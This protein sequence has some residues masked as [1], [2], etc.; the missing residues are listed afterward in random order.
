MLRAGPAH[1][2]YFFGSVE[3]W[4]AGKKV[5]GPVS[6]Y[7]PDLHETKAV[8]HALMAATLLTG[9]PVAPERHEAALRLRDQGAQAL[10]A[11]ESGADH[12]KLEQRTRLT[13]LLRL[14]LEFVD[15]ELKA[16]ADTARQVFAA[17]VRPIVKEVMVDA[18]RVAIGNLNA[19]VTTFQKQ[20]GPAAWKQLVVVAAVGHQSR[21]KEAGVRSKAGKA[22]SARP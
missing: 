15:A 18:A 2:R 14:V 22:D 10:K 6:I 11:F 12:L 17:A 13:N 1:I 16:P 19:W 21:A 20:V 4:V 3:G 5:A 9:W 7:S 8:L